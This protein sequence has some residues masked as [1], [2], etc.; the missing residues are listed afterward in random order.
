MNIPSSNSAL[1]WYTVCPT[2]SVPFTDY[3]VVQEKMLLSLLTAHEVFQ[4]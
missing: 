4:K 2:V 3:N 1:R